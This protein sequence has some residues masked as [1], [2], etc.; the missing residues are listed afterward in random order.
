MGNREKYYE[1]VRE[2]K[3]KDSERDI[4]LIVLLFNNEIK[5]DHLTNVQYR[6]WTA[7]S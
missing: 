6:P 4:K 2:T 3:K 1:E 7:C 5:V